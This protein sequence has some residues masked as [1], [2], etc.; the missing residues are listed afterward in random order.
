MRSNTGTTFSV[1][2]AGIG[3]RAIHGFIG[4]TGH[5]TTLSSFN[6]RQKGILQYTDILN[7]HI[8]EKANG[9]KAFRIIVLEE[10]ILPP[11]ATWSG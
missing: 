11:V 7:K 6:S 3:A 2:L 4:I 1:V 9:S 8:K 5:M 10:K